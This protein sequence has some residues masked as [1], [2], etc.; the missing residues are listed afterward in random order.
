M[1]LQFPMDTRRCALGF[2]IYETVA[3]SGVRFYLRRFDRIWGKK[4]C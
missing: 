1:V 2:A 3:E 4:K